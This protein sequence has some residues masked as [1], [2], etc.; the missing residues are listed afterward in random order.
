MPA[1]VRI[2]SKG[3]SLSGRF[4]LDLLVQRL[5]AEGALHNLHNLVA[6]Y[7]GEEHNCGPVDRCSL[8]AAR[9]LPTSA[10]HDAG[11]P[12]HA[13]SNADVAP[14]WPEAAPCPVSPNRFTGKN[15]EKF[16]SPR[17]RRGDFP[18]FRNGRA[19]DTTLPLSPPRETLHFFTDCTGWVVV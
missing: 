16:S 18:Q 1:V 14:Q 3:A 9:K 12:R 19:N 10:G 17:R 5:H 7:N 13:R 6:E 4:T 11:K 2:G 8:L 15:L